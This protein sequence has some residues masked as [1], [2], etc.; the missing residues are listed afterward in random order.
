MRSSTLPASDFTH[1]SFSSLA[2]VRFWPMI[3]TFTPSSYLDKDRIYLRRYQ[4]NLGEVDPVEARQDF[5][6]PGLNLAAF[7]FVLLALLLEDFHL[8]GDFGDSL[9]ALRQ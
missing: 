7:R 4:Y 9:L 2:T 3:S 6:D 5:L 8:R 1:S